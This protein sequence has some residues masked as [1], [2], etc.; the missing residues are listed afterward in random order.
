MGVVLKEDAVGFEFKSRNVD[1]RSFGHSLICEDLIGI[2]RDWEK[3]EKD[4]LASTNFN[5]GIA[6]PCKM[7]G[8]IDLAIYFS[9]FLETLKDIEVEEENE[10]DS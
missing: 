8:R 1:L 4:A 5:D 9:T 3:G 2:L 6:E 10:D 7:Q